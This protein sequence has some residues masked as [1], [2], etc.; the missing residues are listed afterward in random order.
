MHTLRTWLLK[1]SALMRGREVGVCAPGVCASGLPQCAW[2]SRG[3]KRGLCAMPFPLALES[4]HNCGGS[5]G[6]PLCSA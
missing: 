3:R 1:S 6:A 5:C 4:F 2:Q